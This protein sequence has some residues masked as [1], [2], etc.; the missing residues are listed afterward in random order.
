M[1]N[2]NRSVRRL[3]PLR[4]ADVELPSS[5]DLLLPVWIVE[6]G[7]YFAL[8]E[9]GEQLLA[10]Y[11][12]MAL[13]NDPFDDMALGVAAEL[14]PEEVL[15]KQE[16]I[17]IE[18]I[19]T[20][21]DVGMA[22]TSEADLA[23]LDMHAYTSMPAQI[24]RISKQD[25]SACGTPVPPNSPVTKDFGELG[26]LPIEAGMHGEGR[27]PEAVLQP[28]PTIPDGTNEVDP[29]RDSLVIDG[30]NYA[31]VG[32][33]DSSD[34]SYGPGFGRMLDRDFLPGI[35][36][37]T[38]I[39]AR[40]VHVNHN[41]YIEKVRNATGAAAGD[42][43]EESAH[44]AMMRGESNS[45]PRE[46][47]RGDNRTLANNVRDTLYNES[48]HTAHLQPQPPSTGYN[49]STDESGSSMAVDTDSDS[50]LDE[51][52]F[53]AIDLNSIDG[54]EVNGGKRLKRQRR[55]TLTIN[56]Q[57][58]PRT[59]GH[60]ADVNIE[61][62]STGDSMAFAGRRGHTKPLTTRRQNF[63]DSDD[64]EDWETITQEEVEDAEWHTDAPSD[65]LEEHNPLPAADNILGEVCADLARTLFSRRPY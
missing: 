56:T 13:P 14:D 30:G 44:T 18:F 23:Y 55:P 10:A 24:M 34:A 5:Y 43:R 49:Q 27:L 26:Q 63:L 28:I 53:V 25:Q 61:P 32:Q 48:E 46:D 16:N 4:L 64:D 62:I 31:S 65:S 59:E 22:D 58:N 17:H 50:Q 9:S 47:Q 39:V 37:L 15:R 29:R 2:S 40:P 45:L 57:L 12:E 1:S 41:N 7:H 3:T 33:N 38:N 20:L 8:F 35:D 42:G 60:R 51:D 54:D 21:F 11:A 36:H 52:G 19:T 6:G